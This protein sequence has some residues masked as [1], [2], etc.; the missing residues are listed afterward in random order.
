MFKGLLRRRP[1]PGTNTYTPSPAV[2]PGFFNIHLDC[3]QISGATSSGDLLIED[4]GNNPM[5]VIYRNDKTP[6]ATWGTVSPGGSFLF[7]S[8]D[9]TELT[10]LSIQ[11]QT[12]TGNMLA[13]VTVAGRLRASD[14]DYQIQ[15]AITSQ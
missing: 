14:C 7:I 15:A 10:T 3:P 13:T 5:N 11:Q 9:S 1:A 4:I 2:A 6:N 12:A 8:T